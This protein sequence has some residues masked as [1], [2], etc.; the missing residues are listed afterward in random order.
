MVEIMRSYKFVAESLLHKA[1]NSRNRAFKL[2][3]VESI[4]N[5]LLELIV[6][7]MEVED[8]LRESTR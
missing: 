7:M 3:V 5:Q 1:G 8:V 2:A 6:M 4:R